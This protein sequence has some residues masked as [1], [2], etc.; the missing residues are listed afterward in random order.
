MEV[1]NKS[2]FSLQ[3][4]NC[5]IPF[6][7]HSGHWDRNR[8]F[9]DRNRP[10]YTGRL[11]SMY[12]NVVYVKKR[13]VSAVFRWH[14][15]QDQG[16]ESPTLADWLAAMWWWCPRQR[17]FTIFSLQSSRSHVFQFHAGWVLLS[18]IALLKDFILLIDT[19]LETRL[20][21]ISSEVPSL[22][23]YCTP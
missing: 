3:M 10:L 20:K 7:E 13:P 18:N 4:G 2:H 5:P 21:T 1:L 11:R 16:L 22:Q 17:F 8:M 15:C 19:S 12:Y 9:C 6:G 23:P 14:T